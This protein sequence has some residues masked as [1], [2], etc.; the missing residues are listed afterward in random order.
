MAS[1][2][3]TVNDVFAAMD[4]AERQ[5]DREFD[6]YERILGPDDRW[7]DEAF[8]VVFDSKMTHKQKMA[9]VRGLKK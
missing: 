8:D 3:L 4:K 2:T 9:A 6:A 1:A 7:S 5:A